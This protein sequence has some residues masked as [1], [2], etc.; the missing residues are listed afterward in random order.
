MMPLFGSLSVSGEVTSHDVKVGTT[1]G[2]FV[3]LLILV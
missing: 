1:V 2:R 3:H